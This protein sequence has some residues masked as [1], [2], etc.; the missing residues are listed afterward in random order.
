MF[1]LGYLGGVWFNSFIGYRFSQEEAPND[2]KIGKLCEYAAKN[3]V[4]MPEVLL[5]IQRQ[6]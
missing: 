6:V 3:A 2:R 1:P 4:R 5:F